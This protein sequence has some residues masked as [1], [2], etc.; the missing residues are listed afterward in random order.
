[1]VYSPKTGPDAH[2]YWYARVLG[3]FHAQVLHLGS[4]STNHSPRHMEFLWVR[5][6]GQV[7]GHRFSMKAAW[8]PKVGFVPKEDDMAFGF[9]DPS[10]VVRGCHLVP[11]FSEGQMNRLL[12]AEVTAAQL[13]GNVLDWLAYYVN[14]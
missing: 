11:S 2:P 6:F 12:S 7:P 8:L 3:I 5:W 13:P 10:L 1:M 4:K 9:L 14:M